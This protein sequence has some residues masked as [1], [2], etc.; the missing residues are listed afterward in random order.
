LC[1]AGQEP[2][3]LDDDEVGELRRLAA[4]VRDELETVAQP[5]V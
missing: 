5:A 1:I 4:A 2:R 3:V